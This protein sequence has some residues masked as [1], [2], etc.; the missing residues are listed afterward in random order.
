MKYTQ[1]DLV[2]ALTR[3]YPHTRQLMASNVPMPKIAEGAA[4]YQFINE[5]KMSDTDIQ[6]A[7]DRTLLRRA[8]KDLHNIGWFQY[9]A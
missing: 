9:N 3:L 8:L 7:K 1:E 6:A 2:N 4:I 5:H